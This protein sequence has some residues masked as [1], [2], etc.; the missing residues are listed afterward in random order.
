MS[1]LP[2]DVHEVLEQ[3]YE[4]LHGRL[5]GMPEPPYG[6][7]DLTDEEWAKGC[8][9]KCK[10]PA[11]DPLATANAIIAT[12]DNLRKLEDSPA[13]TET[14]RRLLAMYEDTE[15]SPE[16]RRRIVDEALNG[17]VRRFRDVRL[18]ALYA[19]IHAQPDAEAR[20]AICLS[21]GGIRSATFALGVLQGL[22]GGGILSKFD[23]LSTVSGGGYI[24]SWLSSWSRRHRDGIKGVEDDLVRADTGR[25]AEELRKRPE[26]KIDP[27]P[28]PLRHLREYS[29]YLTPRLGLFSADG[30][31][32][33][34]LYIRNLL[35]NLLVLVPVLAAI[36]ALP[37]LYANLLQGNQG[38]SVNLLGGI[39]VAALAVGFGFLGLARPVEHGSGRW[40]WLQTNAAFVFLCVL[41]LAVAG[42][43]MTTFWAQA[44]QN[45]ALIGAAKGWG[46]LAA[47]AMALVPCLVYYWRYIRTD[48]AERRQSPSR[49]KGNT[50]FR[51]FLIEALAA[52]VGLVTAAGLFYLAAA[53]IFP[54]PLLPVPNPNDG[55]LW[56][57]ILTPSPMAELYVCFSVPLVLIIFFVQAS[58]FVGLSSRLNEDYDREWWGR[59]GAW[60]LLIGIAGGAVSFLSVFGPVLLY[61]APIILGS[62]GG[63]AGIA[64][65][66]LGRSSKTPANGG[67]K[68]QPS[69]L[70]SALTGLAV[71]LFAVVLLAA[72]SLGT[73]VLIQAVKGSESLDKLI[74][75]SQFGATINS[76]TPG[77]QYQRKDEMKASVASVEVE[78]GVRHLK[79]V[80][81]TGAA[82]LGA[83]ALVALVAMG[84]SAFIGV[85]R[86]SMQGLYRNRYIRAYLGASR[87]SR[88][89]DRF[90][91]FDENDNMQ[92][93]ELR[94]QLLWGTSFTDPCAFVDQIREQK[95]ELAKT[96]WY[97]LDADLRDKIQ[98]QNAAHE[99]YA[100]S[101]I[102]GVLQQV[103]VQMQTIDLE[104]GEESS[105]VE[106]LKKNRELLEST[107]PSIKKLGKS[108]QPFHVVNTTLN[109]VSGENLGWQQ[110][111]G[112][113]FTVSP[114]HSGSLYLG[115]RD[116]RVYGGDDG[117]SLGTA[118]AISGA[119]A[120]PN[121]G[122]NS[123]APLAF[124]MTLLNV[125]LGSWL[126]NPGFH[127][128]GSYK[129]S[130]PRGNL[131]PL[132][133]E[134]TGNTNERCPWVYLSDGGHFENLAMYEMVLRRCRTIVVSDGGCDPK[135]TF[136]DLGNAIRKIR[137]DL[138]VPIDI[139]S[140]DMFPRPAPGQPLESG[141]YVATA[142]IRY[143]AV[144]P[145]APD[146]TLIYLKP[147]VYDE[148][149]L[150]RD[151]YNYCQTS[152]DFPHESTADQWFSESQFESYRALGRHVIDVIGGN[153][154][155]QFACVADFADDVRA[156]AEAN[157]SRAKV[158]PLGVA[159]SAGTGEIA[160]V[161]RGLGELSRAVPPPPAA[162][163]TTPM[164]HSKD[165]PQDRRTT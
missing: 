82:E 128:E 103:N 99:R 69:A 42:F 52:V 41:P 158:N 96:L 141:S 144:D 10:L 29:N 117:I 83:I 20:S 153:Q 66:L 156:R 154:H 159:V 130:S 85:N 123:S 16:I 163:A 121:M 125:R 91:G 129:A 48:F 33:A 108:R 46:I 126:G 155:N 98:E 17:A 28:Q 124:I 76:L 105:P 8:L 135:F 21:G 34:A 150:P 53:K 79:T 24:G 151:V 47:V 145:G 49:A 143:S 25:V 27:E 70:T 127:G 110:R 1:T 61:R 138:G 94:P 97:S 60:L 58:I 118:V 132:F 30:W 84:L 147:S 137:I 77:T 43:G 93:Y 102:S 57:R 113:S 109:L 165:A 92:M 3:E 112:A 148:D 26:S 100:S 157:A 71:P 54:T 101:L 56:H 19:K 146:G 162:T 142:K 44:S 36:L 149:Y 120:S 13:L 11:E 63:A 9:A 51:K 87:Y 75:D 90:T 78:R 22:A 134:M 74:V 5:D 136:D 119:A 139:Q 37:R 161:I 7:E 140:R 50:T 116:T 115:Y 164:L 62:L 45:H 107:F 111:K 38:D 31:T 152:P 88:D 65:A 55:D 73:T 6:A 133:W 67:E 131:V 114:L 122:S 4:A 86:F 160:S 59:A 81:S 80:H 2:L 68:S 89:P 104:T 72:I 32:L 95:S 18:A 12:G 14:G 39:T 64:S 40:P 23:F 35:L 15:R 106:M